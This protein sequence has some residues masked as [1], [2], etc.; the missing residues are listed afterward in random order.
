MVSASRHFGGGVVGVLTSELAY[1]LPSELIATRPAE[2]RDSA[3]L[4][5]Y[6]MSDGGIEHWCV[7]DLPRLLE[8]G[9]LL[10]RNNTAVLCA[11][12]RGS[13]CVENGGRGGGKRKRCVPPL[14]SPSTITPISPPDGLFG[15]VYAVHAVYT[16]YT[17]RRAA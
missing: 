13:R 3:R 9:D 7:R 4:L 17:P 12:L 1:D 2:P 14:L 11:R 15:T 16:V 6:S 5:V 10:V 8:A